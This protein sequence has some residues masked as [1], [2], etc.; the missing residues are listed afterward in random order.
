MDGPTAHFDQF[1]NFA[2]PVQGRLYSGG[3]DGRLMGWDLATL[4]EGGLLRP[5]S[6]LA[7]G[8]VDLGQPSSVSHF[9]VFKG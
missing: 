9:L 7:A 8:A 4:G 1:A 2:A 5:S 6:G 3:W